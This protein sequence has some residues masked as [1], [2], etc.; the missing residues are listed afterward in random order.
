[1]EF[2]LGIVAFVASYWFLSDWISW[3][4]THGF[5]E[6][7]GC[8]RCA[9]VRAEAEELRRQRSEEAHHR[10]IRDSEELMRLAALQRMHPVDFENLVLELFRRL[11]W[12]AEATPATGDRGVDGRLRKNGSTVLLQCKRHASPVSPAVVREMVGCIA[13]ER[14]GGGVIATTSSF[15]PGARDCARGQSVELIDGGKL[16]AML[17]EAFPSGTAIPER[18]RITPN[19]IPTNCPECGSRLQNGWHHAARA[20]ILKCAGATCSWWMLRPRERR[21]GRRAREASPRSTRYG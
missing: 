10:A 12:A 13:I 19:R 17:R 2:I 14:A 3:R 5:R 18:F 20:S 1:M 4:C 9:R 16:V 11:G 21:R 6:G 15:T 7:E 8:D